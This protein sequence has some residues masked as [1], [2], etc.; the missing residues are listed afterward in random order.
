VTSRSVQGLKRR[1]RQWQSRLTLPAPRGAERVA[2]VAINMRP[3]RS[4][5]GGGSEWV[6]QTA[7]FLAARGYDV[8]FD[9]RR[10]T[11]AI[12]LVDP[13]VGG[14]VEFGPDEIE[15]Y[16]RTTPGVFCLHRVNENDQRKGTSHVDRL[17]AEANR[18]ADHTVFISEWLRDYHA[19]RWFDR[20]RA[21]SVIT[22]GADPAIYHP[23]GSGD[24]TA[25]EPMRLVTHHWSDNWKKGFAVYQE[26]DRLIAEGLLKD[27]TFQVIGRWPKEVRWRASTTVAP[28]RGARLAALLRAAH[29]Y[30]TASAWEPGGMHFIEGA[31][32]GLPVLYHAD[33]G[34]IVEVARRFGIAFRDDVGSAI[35]Q[36]RQEYLKLRQTVL[37]DA[38]CGNGMSL[39]YAALIQRGIVRRRNPL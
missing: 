3:A 10:H 33:G 27:V 11:D 25:G 31:Q 12:I 38:P 17:L 26:I 16:R 21:H 35:E 15:Q 4:S 1:L 7:R 5:W 23:I 36:M 20:A 9:L 19:E 29:V 13:R 34:G 14:L 39:A 22:N 37:Q 32:C 2:R 6:R 28:V 8:G 30:V 24:M 18:V